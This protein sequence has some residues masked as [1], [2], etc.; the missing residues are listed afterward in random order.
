MVIGE[1]DDVRLERSSIRRADCAHLRDA[2][3]PGTGRRPR[4]DEKR[5]RS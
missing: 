1:R 5:E 2:E 3:F 4:Q